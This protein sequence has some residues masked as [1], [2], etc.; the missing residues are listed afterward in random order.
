MDTE[1]FQKSLYDKFRRAGIE[2]EIKGKITEKI[3][4]K[5]KTVPKANDGTNESGKKANTGLR[6]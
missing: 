5:F 6:N 4:S 1:D 3:L 2:D